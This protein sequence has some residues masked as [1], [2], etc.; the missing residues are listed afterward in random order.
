MHQSKRKGVQRRVKSQSYN[1]SLQ[2][3][4]INLLFSVTLTLWRNLTVK[5]K[6]RT[7]QWNNATYKWSSFEDHWIKNFLTPCKTCL[8]VLTT[9]SIVFR[10]NLWSNSPNMSFPT[11]TNWNRAFVRRSNFSGCLCCSSCETW[12]PSTNWFAPPVPGACSMQCN[13]WT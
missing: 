9:Y 7:Q 13:S 10:A 3:N 5:T 2:Y 11:S 1:C 6:F 4:M 8:L 12:N